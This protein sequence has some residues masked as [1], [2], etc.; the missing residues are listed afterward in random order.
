[1]ALAMPNQATNLTGFSRCNLSYSSHFLSSTPQP[2]VI[3]AEAK[4]NGGICSPLSFCEPS[5]APEVL[6]QGRALAMPNQAIN[7]TGFSRCNLRTP[8]T[9]FH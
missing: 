9:F 1:M 6:Y 8:P 7:L 2:L 4:R 5:H 3:P